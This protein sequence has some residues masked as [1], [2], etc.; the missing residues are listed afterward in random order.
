MLLRILN[1][2]DQVLL[3][4][5]KLLSLEKVSHYFNYHCVLSNLS[6]DWHL[7]QYVLCLG[8][9]GSG[10]TT[11]LNL[12][13][14]RYSPTQ[15]NIFFYDNYMKYDLGFLSTERMLYSD[16]TIKEN[17]DFWISLATNKPLKEIEE[18]TYDVLN[19][20]ELYEYKNRKVHQLSLGMSQRLN[21]VRHFMYAPSILFLDEAFNT[22][23]IRGKDILF[24]VLDKKGSLLYQWDIKSF[25]IV[26]HQYERVLPYCSHLLSIKEH[27]LFEYPCNKESILE[28]ESEIVS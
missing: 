26:D 3:T 9:N 22:L 19:F 16:L 12:L 15:G 24:D 18:K 7:N 28:I 6:W 10:K 25:I 17:L 21:L 20:L 4:K 2:R 27:K 23:D 5:S 11:L 13:S 8:L 1:K 14:Q